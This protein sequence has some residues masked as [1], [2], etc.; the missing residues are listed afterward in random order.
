MSFL[1]L[2]LAANNAPVMWREAMAKL[3]L[4]NWDP[5]L[6]VTLPI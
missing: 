3:G 6:S 1:R 2:F 4:E 5:S